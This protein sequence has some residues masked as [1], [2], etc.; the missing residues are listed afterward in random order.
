MSEYKKLEKEFYDNQKKEI[1]ERIRKWTKEW[2]REDF[3]KQLIEVEKQFGF[4][5]PFDP[6]NILQD[7]IEDKRR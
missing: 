3:I 6:L 4:D 5:L 2:S 1:E 7:S